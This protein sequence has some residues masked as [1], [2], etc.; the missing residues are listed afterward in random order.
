AASGDALLTC[1]HPAVPGRQPLI[2]SR[3]GSGGRQRAPLEPGPCRHGPAH[4][5]LAHVRIPYAPDR[6]RSSRARADLRPDVRFFVCLP[7]RAVTMSTLDDEPA[8]TR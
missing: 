1:P 8:T 2:A 6:Q 7:V 3:P 4:V 5:H